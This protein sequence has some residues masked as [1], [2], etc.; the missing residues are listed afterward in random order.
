M[1]K[2]EGH[3]ELPWHVGE[4]IQSGPDGSNL[5]IEI[6]NYEMFG[7]QKREYIIAH[8]FDGEIDAALIAAAPDLLRQRDELAA[9]TRALMR[10]AVAPVVD[11]YNMREAWLAAYKQF[12]ETWHKAND[13]LIALPQE[14]A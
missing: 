12:D 3:T 8:V 4:V 10:F 7:N 2:F 1:S 11:D 9:I 14:K 5:T 13:A 6:C